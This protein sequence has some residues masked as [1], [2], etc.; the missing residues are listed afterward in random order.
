MDDDETVIVV[1]VQERLANPAQV[2]L[3]LLGQRHARAHSGVNE[4]IGADAEGVDE[5][6]EEF[7]VLFRDLVAKDLDRPI[8]VGSLEGRRTDAVTAGAFGAAEPQPILE[9]LAL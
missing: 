8:R 1:I 4:K 5:T 7:L 9:E 2:R 6:R 3:F